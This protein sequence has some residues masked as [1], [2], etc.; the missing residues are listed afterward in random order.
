MEE[1]SPAIS[2]VRWIFILLFMVTTLVV[3]MALIS[4]AG[5]YYYGIKTSDQATFQAGLASFTGQFN[6]VFENYFSSIF[7]NVWN[8]LSPLAQIAI[9][10]FVLEWFFRRMGITFTSSEQT[11]GRGVQLAFVA[12]IATLS[13]LSIVN[14]ELLDHIWQSLD[15]VAVLAIIIVSIAYF[16]NRIGIGVDI[17]RKATD[18][19]VQAVMAIIIIASLALLSMVNVQG[20]NVVKDIALVVVGFYFGSRRSLSDREDQPGR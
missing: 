13:M 10:L 6:K 17:F 20:A 4:A 18:L 1:K 11:G 16:L 14:R 8:F 3:L 7:P 15:Q 5:F 19:N 2:L 12:G 9:L